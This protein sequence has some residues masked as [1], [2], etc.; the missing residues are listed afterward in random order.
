[1]DYDDLL[2]NWRRLLEERPAIGEHYTEQFKEVLVDE[3]QDTNKV[4]A[5]IVDLMAAKHR[6]VM[7]VGDDAQS[8]YSWRGADFRNIYEF[9]ERYPDAKTFRLDVNYRSTS[10][11]LDLANDSIAHNTRQFPKALRTRRPQGT[12][13]A[14]VAARDVFEQ[15]EFVVSRALE[16]RDEGIPLSEVA[17]LYRSHYHSMELQV[18]MVRRGIPYLVRSGVRFFEQAHIKD[19]IA[20]V[21]IISNPH[22][23]LAWMRA[24]RLVSGIG[25]RT[26]ARLW[27]EIGAST[28]P[29]EALLTLQSLNLVPRR[30]EAS[31][32]DFLVLIESLLHPLTVRSPAAQIEAVLDSGYIEYLRANFT[33]ADAR[34]EDLKQL[35]HFAVRYESSE[36]FLGEVALIGTER[37]SMRDGLYG[38]DVLAGGPEDES[39]VL[40]SIHQAKGLEWRV[41]FLIWAANGRFPTARS[42]REPEAVEEERRLFYVAATRAK[43]ELY[44]CYPL[45]GRE[46]SRNVVLAPSPFIQ[47]VNS[48]LYDQWVI[49]VEAHE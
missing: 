36:A 38:E 3:Y 33:N 1:M 8:I 29:F 21:R 18:E 31:W 40:S 27:E 12:K 25:P 14:V 10:Q 45:L 30:A 44:I 13:P 17:V 42:L 4:Q 24:L 37:Y 43:D 15:A 16:L 48:Q 47:E 5:E 2:L 11:I 41:V 34:I 6:S 9:P 20:H 39:L 49:T 32:K 46:R 35:A 19:V 23:E 22:D 7:V 26:A 28:Q